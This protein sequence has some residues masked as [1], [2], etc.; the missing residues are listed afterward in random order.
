MSTSSDASLGAIRIQAQ[1]RSDLEN[2]PAVSNPEWNGYISQS[3]KEL[4]DLLV[5]AYNNDYYVA[6][7]YTFTTS[8]A[9]SYALPNGTPSFVD[10]NG[11]IAQKFYK[12]LGCDLQ[13]Q[14]SPSGWVT[15][16]RF[17]FIERNKYA[18]PNVAVNW[19][20]YTN[21]RYRIEGN[22]FFMIPIPMTGQAVRLWYI[23]APTSLQ[24][25]LTGYSVG[26]S[27]VIGSMS[28][29]TG[30]VQGMNV[31]SS[32]Q[33]VV[34]NNTTILSVS[35]TT[36]TMSANAFSSVNAN[37]FTMW[38]DATTLDG[39]AGW[40]EYIVVDAAIKAQ[41]K[42]EGDFSPLGAQK[43]DMKARIESMAEGRDV[44][45]AMHVSDV[46]GANAYSWDGAG[47]WG[48]DGDWG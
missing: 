41:I 33:N 27:A 23:P 46:L 3:Y 4:Y 9:Q 40:E 8:N 20:G 44:G 22:N 31:F 12:L 34:P 32:L 18:Y 14:S 35:T 17:E 19:S 11:N 10:D 6:T 39:I 24:Y 1:Q 16:K 37:T 36:M 48:M 26:G 13:Y 29:T 38:N 15:L 2:N 47:G 45:Q 30:I 7:T 25:M 28:D 43:A 42:Q 5:G 21:M